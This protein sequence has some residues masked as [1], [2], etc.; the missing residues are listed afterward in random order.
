MGYLLGLPKSKVP[1]SGVLL[2]YPVPFA[3]MLAVKKFHEN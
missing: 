2:P 1:N 3:N